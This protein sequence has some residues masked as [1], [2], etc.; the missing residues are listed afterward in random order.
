MFLTG[1]GEPWKFEVQKRLFRCGF[2]KDRF[3]SCEEKRLEGL[4]WGGVWGVGRRPRHEPSLC[5][6]EKSA[7]AGD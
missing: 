6:G 7:A 4:T 1:T 2:W 3:G 5:L